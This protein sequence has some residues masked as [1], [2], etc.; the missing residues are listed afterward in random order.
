MVEL[1]MN[2]ALIHE[3]GKE[4]LDVALHRDKREDRSGTLP[5]AMVDHDVEVV[6]LLSELLSGFFAEPEQELID[7][8]HDAADPLALRV[9]GHP[10]KPLAPARIDARIC[11]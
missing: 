3:V 5:S 6:H 4:L 9:L 1:L 11:R 7:H 10:P 2:L 8:E